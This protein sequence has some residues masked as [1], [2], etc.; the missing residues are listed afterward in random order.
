[1]GRP[2]EGLVGF[3]AFT[4]IGWRG[5]FTASPEIFTTALNRGGQVAKLLLDFL[6]KRNEFILLSGVAGQNCVDTVSFQGAFSVLGVGP[7][8]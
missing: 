8:A 6:K 1:M 4:G 7:S 3:G 2:S 5:I